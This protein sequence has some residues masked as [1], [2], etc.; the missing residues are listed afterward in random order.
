MSLSIAVDRLY[1][2]GWLPDGDDAFAAADLDRLPNGLRF[3]TVAAVRRL[4]AAGG[5]DLDVTQH[6]MFKCHRATWRPATG[7]PAGDDR[8]GAVVG[9][10]EREAAVYA[11]AQLR[12]AGQH[13][14]AAE[15]SR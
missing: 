9:S 13:G 1:T 10:C 12:A 3:P 6:L 8:L 7:S 4:F 11:L 5:L 14:P 2:T 15:V